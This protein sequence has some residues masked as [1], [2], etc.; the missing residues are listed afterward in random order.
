[1][2]FEKGVTKLERIERGDVLRNI[3]KMDTHRMHL[4]DGENVQTR[5]LS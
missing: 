2:I 5:A 4:N 3:S 1:M